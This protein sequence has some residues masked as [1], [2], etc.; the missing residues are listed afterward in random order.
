MF[1]GLAKDGNTK[2]LHWMYTAM[3]C[4]KEVSKKS[5]SIKLQKLQRLACILIT[6]G[7]MK[8]TP[9]SSAL[10]TTL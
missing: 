10:K 9:T 2:M 3:V 5:Y 6:T 8:T 1:Y 4:F 7:A